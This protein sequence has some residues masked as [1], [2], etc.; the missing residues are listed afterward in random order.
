MI[1]SKYQVVLLIAFGAI[2]T[3]LCLY[4]PKFFPSHPI[5]GDFLV[6]IAA[7]IAV[8][9]GQASFV[10]LK[11]VR[12]PRQA[13]WVFISIAITAMLT[14]FLT[15]LNYSRLIEQ[16][17]IAKENLYAL[18]GLARVHESKIFQ[19]FS[20]RNTNSNQVNVISWLWA[21]PFRKGA[22]QAFVINAP[23][24]QAESHPNYLRIIFDN[25]TGWASNVAIR[26]KEEMVVKAPPGHSILQLNARIPKSGE[27]IVSLAE[28]NR[29]F[30]N[31]RIVDRRS[32]H[33]E[34]KQQTQR[35][36]INIGVDPKKDWQTYNID[37]QDKT[38]WTPFDPAGNF[39]YA[40]KS[41]DFSILAAVIIAAGT[42]GDNGVFGGS[43][44]IDI[45]D[46][47]LTKPS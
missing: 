46:L 8:M 47:R 35:H 39:K 13:V 29:L 14:T 40:E 37:L 41:P 16:Q 7:S 21:D 43:G 6:G 18:S 22:I 4:T 42:E 20:P 25:K 27:G 10:L 19:D 5:V 17:Y 2:F 45:A 31:V 44:V 30:I 15:S 26:P 38:K 3:G 23:Q 12:M 32:T 34:Y 36:S 11:G 33:W 28:R 1:D 9:I 24:N